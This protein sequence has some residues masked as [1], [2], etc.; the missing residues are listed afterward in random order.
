MLQLDIN[1][2]YAQLLDMHCGSSLLYLETNT[3]ST[4]ADS[5]VL[6]NT[7]SVVLY[8]LILQYYVYLLCSTIYIYNDAAVFL[9]VDFVVIKV[10]CSTLYYNDTVLYILILW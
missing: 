8:I 4:Y 1:T 9:Y 3:D 6:L 2:D 10:L 5:T 7:D